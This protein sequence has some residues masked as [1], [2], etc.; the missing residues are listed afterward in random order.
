MI[1]GKML[2]AESPMEVTQDD[3]AAGFTD[4]AFRG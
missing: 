4:A 3:S 2:S 1:D